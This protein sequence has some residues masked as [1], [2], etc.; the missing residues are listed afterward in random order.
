MIFPEFVYV[1]LNIVVGEIVVV[2]RII[3]CLS[4]YLFKCNKNF[5]TRYNTKR[6][7]FN[8]SKK[9]VYETVKLL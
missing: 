9:Q 4:P 2:K 1:I 5:V 6:G 3:N 7:E 8:I